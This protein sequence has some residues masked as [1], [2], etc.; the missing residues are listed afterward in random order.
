MRKL[1]FAFHAVMLL[2]AG[3]AIAQNDPST[4]SNLKLWLDASDVNP[5]TGN[6]ADGTTIATW[7]DKSGGNNNATVFGGQVGGKV[8]ANQINGKSVIRF[9]RVSQTSGSVYEVPNVDIRS[10]TMPAVTIF[11]V[12]KQGAQSGDQGVWGD[13]NGNWDRFYFSSWPSGNANN[14]NNGGA[15][16]GP[17]NSAAIMPNA[18]I[19]GVL[20]LMTAVYDHGT[21]NGSSI[22]FNGT[23]V[24]SS[25]T[26]NTDATAAQTDLR[27]GWDGDDNAF[28]GD[29]AEMIVY[30]RKLTA[31]EIQTV[32]RYLSTK[33]GV[34]FSTVSITATGPTTFN[35]PGAATLTASVTGTA[36]QWLKD[37]SQ[38]SG[39]TNRNY[40]A[41]ASGDYR[42][43]VT[44]T[45]VD[46]SAAFT[47]TANPP[48]AQPGN[49][50]SF[51][52]TNDYVDLG[53]NASFNATNIKTMEA[54]VK[55]N[56]FATDQEILSHS[57]TGNG[58]ELLVYSNKLAFFC[59]NGSTG[60]GSNVSI[61]T[62][63]L[64]TGVWYHIAATWDGATKESM[65][66]YVNGKAY[67][68]ANRVDLLNI[69]TANPVIT[70]PAYPFKIGNWSTVGTDRY[71]NGTIDE[72]R[73]WNVT[74]SQTDLQSNMYTDLTVPQTG[75]FAYYK[76]DQ[77]TAGA[78]NSLFPTAYDYSGNSLNGT[79]TNFAL[80]NNVSNW[81][82][83]YALVAPIATTATNIG[84][85][86]FMANWNTPVSGT[87]TNY[88]LDVSTAS[89][90]STYVTG[91]NGKSAGTG[92]S[93]NVT[94][95]TKNTGYYF[96]VR[97]DKTSVTGTG[98]FPPAQFVTTTNP[99]PVTWMSFNATP[100]NGQVQLQWVTAKEVNN[101]HF[102]VER[103][104][105]GADFTEIATV[106]GEVNSDVTST[107][108]TIDAAPVAGN[109]FYRIKQVDIDGTSSYSAIRTVKMGA[110][111]NNYVNV[112]PSPAHN[113]VNLQV[114]GDA[115]NNTTAMIIDI[116][117]RTRV[118]FT[119]VSGT[120]SVDVQSL[121]AGT[122]F[123]KLTDGSTY[124][125]IKD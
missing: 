90:F 109:N 69:N 16:L 66:L 84:G 44:N 91:Y 116:D 41:T 87:V 82:E 121:S 43:A 27:I 52:G 2:T 19:V 78:N 47:I 46:T 113:L 34:T 77:G 80:A 68:A 45:C 61:S 75:L 83:S 94:G 70:T 37:G 5:G 10:V 20:R 110:N 40:I 67:G 39:A 117:G 114:N 99:L 59:M 60:A 73:L 88:L 49:A 96:R 104:N 119:I 123:I 103:S 57:I 58:I 105:D 42:V 95:L 93:F 111:G 3:R 101:D 31:C 25:F 6:P 22:Y 33:Y 76:L 30:N 7:K 18:G 62:S 85:W 24:G 71:F 12:Y 35:Q 86:N 48:L 54:W 100:K 56:S 38:I 79:L 106:K 8:Y 1:L 102:V 125:F 120:Q 51:D 50:L 36:Y 26:D 55:F 115:L 108:N 118:Q 13:D 23:Q 98:T 29:I 63:L 4:I 89:D 32:N 21:A 15:S 74:R 9:T 92:N 14:A 17:T 53:S 124:Q 11:T 97:A 72:V 112:Y 64:K 107:Y 65:T 122:Y 81:V 28:N